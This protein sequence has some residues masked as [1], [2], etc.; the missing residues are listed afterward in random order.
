MIS[1]PVFQMPRPLFRHPMSGMGLRMGVGILS[2]RPER[3][4]RFFRYPH[5]PP[6]LTRLPARISQPGPHPQPRRLGRIAL[7]QPPQIRHSRHSQD[8]DCQQS[9]GNPAFAVNSLLNLPPDQ[10][11]VA[12]SL[13]PPSADRSAGQSRPAP[14]RSGGLPRVFYQN[15]ASPVPL[16]MPLLSATKERLTEGPMILSK[17]LLLP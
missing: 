11:R 10:R 17:S 5:P 6:A 8:T 3:G 15:R 7:A 12:P 13:R 14:I 2:P 1:H 9:L 16:P 4:R